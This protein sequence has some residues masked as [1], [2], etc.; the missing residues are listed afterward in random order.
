MFNVIFIIQYAKNM[1]RDK[2]FLSLVNHRFRYIIS[3]KIFS[4][5]MKYELNRYIFMQKS[6]LKEISVSKK[7][8]CLSEFQVNYFCYFVRLEK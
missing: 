3:I 5:S 7:R 4:T 1:V 8:S 2:S 6:R